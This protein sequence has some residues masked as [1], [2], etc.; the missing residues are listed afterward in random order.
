MRNP[1]SFQFSSDYILILQSQE[2]VFAMYIHCML[3]FWNIQAY[4]EYNQSIATLWQCEQSR[5][6]MFGCSSNKTSPLI[7]HCTVWNSTTAVDVIYD[8]RNWI[9]PLTPWS[10]KGTPLPF[11]LF[12]CFSSSSSSFSSSSILFFIQIWTTISSPALY[13]CMMMNRKSLMI[14]MMMRG[15][16]MITGMKNILDIK[17]KQRFPLCI[18]IHWIEILCV[19]NEFWWRMLIF[20]VSWTCGTYYFIPAQKYPHQSS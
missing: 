1:V 14:K 6:W 8:M 10:P 20:P 16:S 4:S 9:S 15:K 5:I 3:V 2:K 13:T 18:Q 12:L 7:K 19:K 11:Y 17:G